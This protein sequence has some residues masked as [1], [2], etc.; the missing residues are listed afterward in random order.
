MLSIQ[1]TSTNKLLCQAS[2]NWL[3]KLVVVMLAFDHKVA[4]L[5]IVIEPGC[6]GHLP[7]FL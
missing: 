5:F 3:F 2:G 7:A 6:T 4:F 1:Y